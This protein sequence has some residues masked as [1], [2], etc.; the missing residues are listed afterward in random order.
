MLTSNLAVGTRCTLQLMPLL[1]V[2]TTPGHFVVVLPPATVAVV[3]VA[4][5]AALHNRDHAA[6]TPSPI[7]ITRRL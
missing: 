1:V 7:F 3:P 2:V 6:A 5:G 4:L